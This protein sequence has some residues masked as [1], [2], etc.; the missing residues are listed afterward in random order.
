[1]GQI[2]ERR[3]PHQEHAAMADAICRA[4]ASRTRAGAALDECATVAA[5]IGFC[6]FSYLVVRSAPIGPELVHHWTSSGPRWKAMYRSRALHLCDPRILRTQG[7]SVPVAWDLAPA[8]PDPRARAFAESAE[9]HGLGSGVAWSVREEFGQ[10]AIVSWDNPP[11]PSDAG[12][13]AGSRYDFATLALLAGFVH[14]RMTGRGPGLRRRL[15][16]PSLT[17]RE[18]E[19]LNLAARGM[20]SADIAIKVGIAERTANFHIGNIIAKLG[21]LN[22]GEAIARGVALDLVKL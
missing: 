17:P 22:R 10:R 5:S 13:V 15:A 16:G 21:A 12:P 9:A 1:M 7:R 11:L 8:S 2:T 4:M 14:E 6:G 3:D 18:I 19:C 20:T